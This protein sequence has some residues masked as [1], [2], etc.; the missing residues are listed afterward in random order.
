[1]NNEILPFKDCVYAVEYFQSGIKLHH[2]DFLLNWYLCRLQRSQTYKIVI[3]PLEPDRQP[4]Q[5][6]AHPTIH[7]W[8]LTCTGVV[9]ATYFTAFNYGSNQVEINLEPSWSLNIVNHGQSCKNFRF[10]STS[11][12]F[13]AVASNP[14]V[15]IFSIAVPISHTIVAISL[16]HKIIAAFLPWQCSLHSAL[17]LGDCQGGGVPPTTNHIFA[18]KS[19]HHK[20][21]CL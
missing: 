17:F 8:Q 15:N 21:C 12:P 6:T 7:F 2:N 19:W 10:N 3:L 4:H 1:M 9:P 16:S 11:R 20:F 13:C 5:P 14:L 18:P